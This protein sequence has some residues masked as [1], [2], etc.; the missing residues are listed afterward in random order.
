MLP[1]KPNYSDLEQLEERIE[2]SMRTLSGNFQDTLEIYKQ[3]TKETLLQ[4][5][6]GINGELNSLK[7]DLNTPSNFQ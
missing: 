3:E 1:E 6:K 2:K 7:R 4:M 5:G